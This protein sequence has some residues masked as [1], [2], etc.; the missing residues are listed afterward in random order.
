MILS[1]RCVE[2]LTINTGKMVTISRP[3][4]VPVSGS[5]PKRLLQK[6][7]D[8]PVR[9]R[10]SLRRAPGGEHR[11]SSPQL[12]EMTRGLGSRAGSAAAGRRG[13][14]VRSTGR[15]RRCRR[16]ARQTGKRPGE[17]PERKAAP[18]AG[19]GREERGWRAVPGAAAPRRGAVSF[20]G[21]R[22]VPAAGTT[23][24]GLRGPAARPIWR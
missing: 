19:Q 7:R 4:P 3:S 14:T 21:R 8:L 13:G 11:A 18:G 6:R 15:S 10:E 23:C 20:R 16:A 12:P 5:L 9:R 17:P 1:T 2:N 22:L 24:W